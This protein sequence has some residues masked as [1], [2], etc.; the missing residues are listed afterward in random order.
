[1]REK[2]GLTLSELGDGRPTTAQSWE[3]GKEPRR[4][5]WQGI[6]ER[7]GLSELFIFSGRPESQADY[8]FIAKWTDEIEDLKERSAPQIKDTEYN[9]R[10]GS[11]P[12]VRE[13]RRVLM[14]PNVSPH[15]K[16]SSRVDCEDYFNKLLDAAEE[17]GEPNAFPVIHDRLRKLLPIHE[18]ET[19]QTER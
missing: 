3:R 15:R 9:Q 19:P 1:M 17:S 5:N 8:A 10:D 2:Q 14:A 7:L 13:G 6:S 11:P 18:W 4:K 12:R 16:P